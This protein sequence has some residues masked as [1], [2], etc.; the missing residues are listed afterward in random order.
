V[1]AEGSA[2]RSEPLDAV[3]AAQRLRGTL[4]VEELRYFL[5]PDDAD[6]APESRQKPPV[7]RWYGKVVLP[8]AKPF[9]LRF[10]YVRRE[11]GAGIVAVA[12]YGTKGFS[13]KDWTGFEGEG[14]TTVPGVPGTW[15]GAPYD[16]V[17]AGQLPPEVRG[18]IP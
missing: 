9:K 1:P 17:K 6:L 14:T 13:G 8:G 2:F 16:Y 10:L 18:C 12:P 4:R 3:R 15:Q 5:G 7:E 11:V